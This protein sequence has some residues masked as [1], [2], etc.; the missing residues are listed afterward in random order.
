MKPIPNPWFPGGLVTYAVDDRQH[1]AA[2]S[3]KGS[4]FFGRKGSATIVVFSL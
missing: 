1:V 2:V 4:F 3:G